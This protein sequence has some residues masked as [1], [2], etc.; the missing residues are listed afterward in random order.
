MTDLFERQITK[1]RQKW[2]NWHR[3]NPKVYELF[4]K[5]TFQAIRAG[6]QNFGAFAIINRIRWYT[7]VETKGDV[8]KVNNACAAYYSRLFME[9]NP[10]YE[11]FFRTKQM[12]GEP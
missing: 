4:C 5:F 2:L 9:E 11:G 12:K 6:R 7:D 8:F 1:Q 3:K 10:Q